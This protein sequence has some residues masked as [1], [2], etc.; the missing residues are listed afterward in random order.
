MADRNKAADAKATLTGLMCIL[1][2]GLR[3]VRVW[4]GQP[5]FAPVPSCL[6][7]LIRCEA[8]R[9]SYCCWSLDFIL[10]RVCV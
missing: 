7:E 2:L 1:E 6:L 4:V 5:I 9:Q 8:D 10:D 3:A